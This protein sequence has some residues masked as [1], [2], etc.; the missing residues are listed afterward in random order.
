MRSVWFA[1][2][3][4]M[5]LGTGCNQDKIARLEKENKELAVK[6]ESV[7]KAANLDMQAKCAQ[8]ARVEF[9]VWEKD[10]MADFTNHYNAKVNK[11]FVEITNMGRNQKPYVP[12][13]NRIVSDAF[14][15]KV[16]GE[17]MWMNNKGKK[18]WEVEP[19]WC[20]V[21]SLSGE[22][23]VCKSSEEFDSLIKQF[24]EQ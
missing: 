9:E 16:Y 13:V 19:Y 6:L 22:E 17:Y 8:Q 3:G 2:V 24:M 15:G 12:A 7:A 1:I 4:L 20:K 21:R 5:L 10:P 18:Y 11:C 23:T 14:E